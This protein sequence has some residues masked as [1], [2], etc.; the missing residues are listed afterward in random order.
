MVLQRK[1]YHTIMHTTNDAM[2]MDSESVFSPIR[3]DYADFDVPVADSFAWDK[4]LDTLNIP[5]GAEIYLYA[6]RSNKKPGVDEVKL[7]NLDKVA[8]GAAEESG[9][10]VI[11]RPNPDLSYCGWNRVEDAELATSGKKHREAAAFADEA[12]A[13]YRLLRWRIARTAMGVVFEDEILLHE[14]FA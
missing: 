8:L 4:I 11:Y 12:Y 3:A 1:V 2:R 7:E 5:V 13:R 14:K 10:L 6:F 9:G